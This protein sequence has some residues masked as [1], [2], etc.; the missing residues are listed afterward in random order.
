M[1]DWANKAERDGTV[2]TIGAQSQIDPEAVM[3]THA[4]YKPTEIKYIGGFA[5]PSQALFIRKEAL[6][7]LHDK[8]KKPVVIGVVGTTLRT[9]NYQAVWGAAFLGWNLKWVR[10]YPRTS[11]LRQALERGEIDMTSL[12]AF[13]DIN[14][15]LSTGKFAVASQ[16]GTVIDGKPTKRKIIGDALI[17]SEL[18]K[19]KIKDP[20]AQQAF[21]YGET[22][23]QIGFW[24]ALP[25]RHAGLDRR[26]LRQSLQCHSQGC[27]ISGA[28]VKVCTRLAGGYQSRS[29]THCPGALEGLAKD[30]G[31]HSGRIAAPGI[32]LPCR[33]RAPPAGSRGAGLPRHGR[34]GVGPQRR[35][36]DKPN[37]LPA[38]DVKA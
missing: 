36:G 34:F 13:K 18:V 4:K 21:E 10:G 24:L 38:Q 35:A 1:N 6:P 23:S 22:V 2:A 20:L 11:D 19:G 3:R 8:S 31:V 33:M 25:P 7:R 37:P 30:P 29:G 12:G 17:I 15:L 9:G 32:W 14:Y 16:S 26:H 28:A 5:A 27:E